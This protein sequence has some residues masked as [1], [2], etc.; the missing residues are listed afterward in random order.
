MTQTERIGKLIRLAQI[1]SDGGKSI[2]TSLI[3]TEEEEMVYLAGYSAKDTLILQAIQL[4]ARSK[5]RTYRFSV[6]EGPD[7][8]GNTS[9][10]VYFDFKIEGKREQISFHSFN[11]KL[12]KFVKNSRASTWSKDT[13]SRETA[14][15]LSRGV[16]IR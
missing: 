3:R 7:Q 8:N 16:S 15:R 1:A 11:K 10:I 2:R 5:D 4:I 6:T 13:S 9:F 12:R 14:I